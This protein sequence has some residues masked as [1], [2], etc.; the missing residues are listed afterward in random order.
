MRN[1]TIHVSNFKFGTMAAIRFD[2][3]A[4]TGPDAEIA[5]CMAVSEEAA[6]NALKRAAGVNGIKPAPA[7]PPSPMLTVVDVEG[8]ASLTPEHFETATI[9]RNSY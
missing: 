9:V 3:V 4:D 8:F 1:T 5:S 7:P 6:L 2:D